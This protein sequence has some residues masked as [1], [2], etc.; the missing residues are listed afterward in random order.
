MVDFPTAIF[1]S[2]GIHL[3]LCDKRLS[4]KLS[5]KKKLERWW[6]LF[7]GEKIQKKKIEKK[8]GGK[9]FASRIK[10]IENKRFSGKLF[11]KKLERNEKYFKEK[12][13]YLEEKNWTKMEEKNLA[14]RIKKIEENFCIKNI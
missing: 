6:K 5:K 3:S 9:F 12:I 11:K 10:K 13:I 2:F 1:S 7:Q 8:H 4:E 14:S